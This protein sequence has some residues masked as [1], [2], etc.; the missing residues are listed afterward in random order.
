MQNDNDEYDGADEMMNM[1]NKI[2]M[3]LIRMFANEN[4]NVK[5]E[6]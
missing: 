6:Q 5:D 1:E 4:N 3:K 2:M